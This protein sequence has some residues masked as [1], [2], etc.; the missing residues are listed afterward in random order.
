M[1][2]HEFGHAL[3]LSHSEVNGALMAPF[4]RGYQPNFQLHSDDVMGI[5]SIYGANTGMNPAPTAPSP[6]T[7]RPGT[8]RPTPTQGTS[9]LRPDRPPI[10]VDA[11]VDAVTTHEVDGE[12][13][14][15]MFRG[16]SVVKISTN[17]QIAPG[18]PR[19][20]S[21][22]FPGLPNNLDAAL[23]WPAKSGWQKINGRWWFVETAPAKTY[24][25]KGSQYW[26]YQN[27]Q[28]VEGPSPIYSRWGSLPSSIDSAFRW[29]GNNR[30]YF[31]KG[32]DCQLKSIAYFDS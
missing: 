32:R 27:R 30:V 6:T 12:H 8:T 25:F 7:R 5:Q 16:D 14:T 17:Y 23:Y 9:T 4:Y 31:I 24:F 1:A 28:L 29:T 21:A 22:E 15:Y 2:A 18:Y 13:M 26:M 20:I 11:T 19:S 10:C 3:G